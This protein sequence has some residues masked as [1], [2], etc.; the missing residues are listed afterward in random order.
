MYRARRHTCFKLA[1]ATE[2]SVLN[3]PPWNVSVCSGKILD[4]LFLYGH[5]AKTSKHVFVLQVKKIRITMISLAAFWTRWNGKQGKKSRQNISMQN[6]ELVSNYFQ[7]NPT[8][9]TMTAM[10]PAIP[11]INLQLVESPECRSRSASVK[12]YSVCSFEIATE[13]L[14]KF[15]SNE[16]LSTKQTHLQPHSSSE[17]LYTE[18][19]DYYRDISARKSSSMS[20]SSF[21]LRST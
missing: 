13:Y 9:A 7:I 20:S 17:S 4:W 21:S 16:K 1:F 6:I 14:K 19:S 8:A 5:C 3:R 11:S 2:R 12:K 15:D 10:A 18:S